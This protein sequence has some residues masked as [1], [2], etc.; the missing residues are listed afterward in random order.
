V[1]VRA[2]R[3]VPRLVVPIVVTAASLTSCGETTIEPTATTVADE[4]SPTTSFAPT[5][6]TAQLLAQLAAETSMLSHR[7]I[8]NEDQRAALA[9]IEALWALIRPVIETDR[10][11]LLRGFETVVDLLRRSVERRRPAD[12][13]KAHK[14]LLTLIAAYEA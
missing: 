5:G 8:E 6:S 13:D 3:P 9:R 12:A 10:E 7:V 4:E 2:W 11:E 1:T 14:N